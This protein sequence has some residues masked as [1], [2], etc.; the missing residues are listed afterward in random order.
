MRD[1]L[2]NEADPAA[3]LFHNIQDFFFV[4]AGY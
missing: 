3:G 4:N 1:G 2:S